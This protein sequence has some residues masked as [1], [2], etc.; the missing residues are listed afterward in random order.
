MLQSRKRPPAPRQELQTPNVWDSPRVSF[1]QHLLSTHYVPA[2]RSGR[3]SDSSPRPHSV[4]RLIV[5]RQEWGDLRAFSE[6]T[7]PRQ[8]AAAPSFNYQVTETRQN[9]PGRV[10]GQTIPFPNLFSIC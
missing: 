6:G 3:G 1:H 4:H 8:G 10:R 7:G 2:A 5:T 9:L